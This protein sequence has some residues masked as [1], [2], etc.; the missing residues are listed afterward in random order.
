MPAI[1]KRKF[2][3]YFPLIKRGIIGLGLIAVV[4]IILSVCQ[5]GQKRQI[6]PKL[7]YHLLQ[8]SSVDLKQQNNRVNVLLLGIGGGSHEGADMT[9]TMMVVSINLEKQNAAL[10]SI[11]RDIWYSPI[12][13]KINAAYHYGE[14]KSPGKGLVMAKSAVEE[15]VGLPI[16]YAALLDFSGFIRIIDAVG[17]VDV[18]IG[19]TFTDPLY[20]IAGK[21]K[22][23]CGGDREYACRY[24]T[25]TFNQGTEH[26]D[27]ERALKYVRSRHAQGD[28][29]TDFSRSRRQQAVILALKNKLLQTTNFTNIGLMRNILSLLNQAIVTDISLGESLVFLNVFN[30][31]LKNLSNINL[32]QDEPEKNI[33]GLLVNPPLW[34]YDNKWVLVPKAGSGNFTQIHLYVKCLIENNTNCEGFLK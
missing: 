4:W 32:V 13:D 25:I 26:M 16:H 1:L 22:D 19:E 29:G 9:D 11:P 6:T 3:K 2:Q 5:F 17:G 15:V 31:D 12:K 34:Q 28:T 20:P 7:I 10:I 14:E 30:H 33:K 27:G 18:K 8:G 21:E 23:D 24:E